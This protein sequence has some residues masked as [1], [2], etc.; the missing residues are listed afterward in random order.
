MYEYIV[1]LRKTTAVKAD[2]EEEARAKAA[3]DGLEIY[4]VSATGPRPKKWKR[5]MHVMYVRSIEWG[6]GAGSKGTI[7]QRQ[8]K[9]YGKAADEYQVFWVEPDAGGGI[10]WTTPFDVVLASD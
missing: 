5:G 8:K 2:T 9:D 3:E 10:F 4:N 1:A 7:V 6:P